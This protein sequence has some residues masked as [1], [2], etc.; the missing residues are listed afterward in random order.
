[1]KSDLFLWLLNKAVANYK[2]NK[3]ELRHFFLV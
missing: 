1:M 2:V 3:S